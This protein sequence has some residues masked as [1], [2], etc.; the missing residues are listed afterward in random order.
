M[1]VERTPENSAVVPIE[2][3]DPRLPDRIWARIAY[4]ENDCWPWT[5][6]VCTRA[7]AVYG[8]VWF[9]GRNRTPHRV[10]FHVLVRPILPSEDAHH[11]GC[12]SAL[13]ANPNHILAVPRSEHW[14]HGQADKTHCPQGHPYTPEN[15]HV[16]YRRSAIGT[17]SP[18][19]L[20]KA[21]MAA[22]KRRQRARSAA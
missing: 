21:C 17:V 8:S 18:N 14:G 22:A 19:R 9:E 4:V 11:D 20:C 2:Y 16:A 12:W 1:Q 13:C 7:S 15:T 10:V 6:G 5:G 3:G